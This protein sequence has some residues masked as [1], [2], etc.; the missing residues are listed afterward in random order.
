M[1]TT[2]RIKLRQSTPQLNEDGEAVTERTGTQWERVVRVVPDYDEVDLDRLSP[3]A[4]AL[5]EAVAASP[6]STANEV[7]VES[8]APLR[9]LREDWADWYSPERAEE[10]ERR[11]WSAWDRYRATDPTDPH[12]W[13]E[14]QAAK[15]PDGWHILGASPRQPVPTQERGEEWTSG[16]VLNY[17]SAQG[18]PIAAST[19]RANVARGGAPQPVR[20]VGRTPLWDSAEIRARYAKQ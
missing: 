16:Q 11:L 2:V 19:W 18:A 5:A 1:P 3:R 10:G 9:E 20:K 8:D 17:L 13:L 7:W 4:R 14:R 15:I 12:D 6:L